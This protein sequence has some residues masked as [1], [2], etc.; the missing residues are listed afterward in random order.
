MSAAWSLLRSASWLDNA[1]S[2]LAMRASS[3]ST[4]TWSVSIFAVEEVA[5]SYSS[6]LMSETLNFTKESCCFVSALDLFM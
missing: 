4:F 5:C 1:F 6:D 2:K 3:V